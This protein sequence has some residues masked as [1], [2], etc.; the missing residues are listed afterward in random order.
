MVA[1]EG[2]YEEEGFEDEDDGGEAPGEE[3][4]AAKRRRAEEGYLDLVRLLTAEDGDEISI[5]LPGSLHVVRACY[6]AS[7]GQSYDCTAVLQSQVSLPPIINTY[8]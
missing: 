3:D 6:T 8:E 4:A 1:E 2:E 5:D 7:G